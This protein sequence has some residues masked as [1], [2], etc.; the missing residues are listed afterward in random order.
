MKVS[1][2]TSCYNRE[3]TIRGAIE[4]V[5][6]QD[7]P[8]IEYIVVDGASKDKSL[9]VINEYKDRIDTIISEPDKGMYE[10]INKG[11]R[12]AT[13]DIIGLVH[14]DDFLFAEHTIS[15]IVKA[16][17]EQGADMVYG[18]GVFVDYDDIDLMKRNWVSGE[19]KKKNIKK[20]WLP[21]HPTVYIKKACMEEWGLYDESY[22]IAADSDLLVRYLYEADLKVHYLDKYIVRM[23]MG[24]LST[25]AGKSKQKWKE[26]LRMYRSHGINPYLALI[27]KIASKIPQFIQAWL[28]WSEIPKAKEESLI[29]HAGENEKE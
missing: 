15:E 16:F 1:I 21:L 4:S 11:I 3:A 24:G 28:P 26:D 19:Y 5:L 17:E 22:K 13:G 10:A 27:G 7:Y 20:G 9:A 29:R 18:N 14:S 25:D 2:I 8:D 6:E 23:R 12:A